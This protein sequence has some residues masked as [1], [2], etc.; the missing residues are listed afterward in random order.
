MKK[1][2]NE[3][4]ARSYADCSGDWGYNKDML[5]DQWKAISELGTEWH[6]AFSKMVRSSLCD[7]ENA[8]FSPVA[9]FRAIAMLSEITDGR[10]RAELNS[11]LGKKISNAER[12]AALMKAALSEDE[13]NI[14]SRLSSSLWLDEKVVQSASELEAALEKCDTDAF[15]CDM[16]ASETEAER[17][18]WLKTATGGGAPS[19][20]GKPSEDEAITLFSTSLFR[21]AWVTPFE[22]KK[23]AMKFRTDSGE[24]VDADFLHTLEYTACHFGKSFTAVAKH[25]DD[26]YA[27]W[28]F[29]P[30]KD[31]SVRDLI[32]ENAITE[33]I[34]NPEDGDDMYYVDLSVPEFDFSTESD[35]KTCLSKLGIKKLFSLG[36]DLSPISERDDLALNS[37]K[38]SARI[39]VNRLGVDASS[40]VKL[41]VACLGIPPKN[42]ELKITLNRPFL[43]AL[44]KYDRLPLYVGALTDPTKH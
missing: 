3:S 17:Q 30:D 23:K 22:K 12:V 36:A 29:L 39:A 5:D 21:G 4:V 37:A 15:V 34:K 40:A 14:T 27:L 13:T 1:I 31:V 6:S 9:R 20:F 41:S 38:E 32:E 24:T 26:A 19:D 28:F 18:K 25:L 8:V 44:T 33:L 10:T 42:G 7:K 16:T 43:F 35:L 2:R 11:A